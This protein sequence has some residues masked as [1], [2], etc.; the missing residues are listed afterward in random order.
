MSFITSPATALKRQASKISAA[1]LKEQAS[2]L[3]AAA[4][5]SQASKL[6][7][8]A[9]QSQASKIATA[10]IIKHTSIVTAAITKKLAS[11]TST[12]MTIIRPVGNDDDEHGVLAVDSDEES[13]HGNDNSGADGDVGGGNDGEW[14]SHKR[15]V[16]LADD[17]DEDFLAPSDHEL[18][19]DE[20][21]DDN[22]EAWENDDD[23]CM[24]VG[25]GGRTARG[26]DI[27]ANMGGWEYGSR[28]CMT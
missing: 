22:D 6:A 2:K 21:S 28:R 5:K 25:Y 26:G 20:D 11:Q 7:A 27:S 18:D 24:F 23:E 10:A 4:L 12:G 17:E 16:A 13:A 3:A 1:A 19:H 8:A 15:V 14:I 9:L